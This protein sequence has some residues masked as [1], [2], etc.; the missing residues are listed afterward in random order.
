MDVKL[1]WVGAAEAIRGF[2]NFGGGH[3]FKKLLTA[4][5]FDKQNKKV[6]G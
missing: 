4:K 5:Y 3:R 6:I 2:L 1:F